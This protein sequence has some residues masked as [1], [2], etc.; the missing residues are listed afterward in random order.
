MADNSAD[1]P[2]FA[3]PSAMRSLTAEIRISV[4]TMKRISATPNVITAVSTKEFRPDIPPACAD[5]SV[6]SPMSRGNPI[7]KMIPGTRRRAHSAVGHADSD[8]GA[9]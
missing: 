2:I 1:L 5:T 6:I 8:L 7:F 3:N 4:S 9:R